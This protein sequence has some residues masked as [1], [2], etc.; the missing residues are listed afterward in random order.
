M[1]AT[2]NMLDG[3]QTGCRVTSE[4]LSLRTRLNSQIGVNQCGEAYCVA[5]YFPALNGA[6]IG[7]IA[8]AVKANY[9]LLGPVPRSCPQSKSKRV[10]G[11]QAH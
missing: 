10:K 3:L 1:N 6:L 11:A 9:A 2:D 4:L 5:D 8:T 7:A